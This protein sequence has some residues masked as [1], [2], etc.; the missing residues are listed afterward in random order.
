MCFFESGVAYD[1]VVSLRKYNLTIV[2]PL[3]VTGTIGILQKALLCRRL[4]YRSVGGFN[5]FFAGGQLAFATVVVN[6][7]RP[8]LK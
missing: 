2:N 7:G 6:M 3:C 8:Q 5:A 4:C 1:T